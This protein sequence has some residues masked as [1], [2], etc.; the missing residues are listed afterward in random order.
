M[1]VQRWGFCYCLDV[2]LKILQQ[3]VQLVWTDGTSDFIFIDDNACAYQ[4]ELA[5]EFLQGES[6]HGIDRPVR[7]SDMNPTDHVW[8]VLERQDEACKPLPRTIPELCNVLC[9]K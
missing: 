9:K 3:H 8:D 5:E 4:P 1:D 6:I 2:Q 7:S